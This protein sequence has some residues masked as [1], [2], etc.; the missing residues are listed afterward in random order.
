MAV[1]AGEGVSGRGVRRRQASSS[2]RATRS[3]GSG[4][5]SARSTLCPQ[6]ASSIRGPGH[7][8]P[9]TRSLE[10][11]WWGYSLTETAT[12]KPSREPVSQRSVE[13]SWDVP[14]GSC[15]GVLPGRCLAAPRQPPQVNLSYP[16]AGCLSKGLQTGWQAPLCVAGCCTSLPKTST[17]P[18]G[19]SSNMRRRLWVRG[20]QAWQVVRDGLMAMGTGICALFGAMPDRRASQR[21][22]GK[23]RGHAEQ[24]VPF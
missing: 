2:G 11:F 17:R 12:R 8:P 20:H 15:S 9:T 1:A 13:S 18:W 6:R 7:G 14:R 16:D 4:A 24:R 5:P 3:G 23:P 10:P 22:G 21:S 19:A